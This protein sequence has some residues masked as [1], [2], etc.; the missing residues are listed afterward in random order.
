MK[1][2]LHFTIRYF[3]NKI[4]LHITFIIKKKYQIS[5]V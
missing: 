4:I 1:N 5:Y 3:L 2:T